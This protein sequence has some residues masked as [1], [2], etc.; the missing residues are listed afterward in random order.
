[1]KFS[2]I[3][4][5]L[6]NAAAV[7]AGELQDRQAGAC[8]TAGGGCATTPTNPMYMRCCSGLTCSNHVCV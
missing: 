3:A 2:I 1:M 6:V 5:L 7:M 4:A 8:V